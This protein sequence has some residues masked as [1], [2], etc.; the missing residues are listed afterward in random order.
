M[1]WFFIL[2]I[3]YL[4]VGISIAS[5]M[6]FALSVPIE[7]ILEQEGIDIDNETLKSY[8]SAQEKFES[9]NK[10]LTFTTYVLLMP[11]VGLWLLL[12]WLFQKVWK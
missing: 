5:Y 10:Y 1:T 2:V 11:L 9:R 7:E 6:F 4:L 12:S 8:Y 3:L